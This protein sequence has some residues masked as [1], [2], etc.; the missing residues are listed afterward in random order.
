MSDSPIRF[1]IPRLQIFRLL[2]ILDIFQN[3]ASV[4]ATMSGL[5]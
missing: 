1:Q 3:A 5:D 2:V 4:R